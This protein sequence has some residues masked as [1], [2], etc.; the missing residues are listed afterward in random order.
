MDEPEQPA[1]EDREGDKTVKAERSKEGS[2]Q[3]ETTLCGARMELPWCAATLV[4][5]NIN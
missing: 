3:A 4:F 2:F 1:Q 5:S